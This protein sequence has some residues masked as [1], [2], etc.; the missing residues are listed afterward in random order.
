MKKVWTLVC[1]I[2]PEVPG[3]LVGDPTRLRQVLL[4]LLGNA[5]KFTELGKVVMRSRWRRT[6]QSQACC[7]SRS[8]TTGIGI[9]SEKLG[10]VFER[11]T[12]A[13]SSTTRRY[14]VPASG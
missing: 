12:Q 5:I 4:N 2:A 1:E 6:L 13:D 9:S 8:L 7:G 11:F 3:D 10:A 14:G